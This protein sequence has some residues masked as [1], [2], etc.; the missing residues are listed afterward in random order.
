MTDPPVSK[1]RPL[2]GASINQRQ[3]LVPLSAT[4]Q[5]LAALLDASSK[6]E[7]TKR[8]KMQQIPSSGQVKVP[9]TAMP[10]ISSHKSGSQ[11]SHMAALLATT[12]SSG[13]NDH[14]YRVLDLELKTID[15]LPGR[16]KSI[17]R[18]RPSHKGQVKPQSSLTTS[19]K[20]NQ[21]HST[22]KGVA[23]PATQKYAASVKPTRE[24]TK[25][26]TT[27][28]T[29]SCTA[30]PRASPSSILPRKDNTAIP[31]NHTN[32]SS[33]QF[34]A[35]FLSFKSGGPRKRAGTWAMR[36]NQLNSAPVKNKTADELPKVQAD[37]DS[38]VLP[39]PDSKNT[40]KPATWNSSKG[41][42]P[43][44]PPTCQTI[45]T[46]TSRSSSDG[47]VSKAPATK[48]RPNLVRQN[49]RN[50]HGAC[51]HRRASTRHFSKHAKALDHN[52][53]TLIE[54]PMGMDGQT[55]T[56]PV[57]D[58]C[59]G[60]VPC[61]SSRSGGLPLCQG[62]RQP[63]CLRTV[64]KSGSIHKGR[65]FYA[66]AVARPEQCN[67]F[68]WADEAG[69]TANK[70]DSTT[71]FV[72][73]QVQA[74]L[75][76]LQSLTL[77]ELRKWAVSRQLDTR[78]RRGQVWARIALYVRDEISRG[79]ETKEEAD[80]DQEEE[81]VLEGQGQPQMT[82]PLCGDN[83]NF[84]EESDDELEIFVPGKKDISRN[85][86][87]DIN[88]AKDENSG[89][90][91]ETERENEEEL[92]IL[93]RKEKMETKCGPKICCPLRQRL[94]SLFG[95][96]DFRPGQEWTIRRCLEGQRTLLVAPT[97]MG[98]SLCYALPAAMQ[99]DGVVLVISPLLS[100]IQDQ[101]RELPPSLPAASL[102]GATPS[103]TL[104]QDL[105]RGRLRILYVSPERLV[106]PSFRRLL[107]KTT[108]NPSTQAYER[109]MPNVSL[110]CVDEAHCL[111]QVSTY[112]LL[113]DMAFVLNSQ[114][115]P[116]LILLNSL[117]GAIISD[118]AT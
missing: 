50:A 65:K 61:A 15:Q 116:R 63:C 75:G 112:F 114:V 34:A 52:E 36:P 49:L 104:L 108:W 26:T 32:P 43:P 9:T 4:S 51:R 14:N 58:F 33:T 92:K 81:L 98:K 16:K 64:R 95:H 30:R 102:S 80:A 7:S 107:S 44:S 53:V 90:D 41:M 117:S 94:Q 18:R 66:C 87:E 96:A 48:Y 11:P 5:K 46:S 77:P 60:I 6:Q 83:D 24:L 101:L 38:T 78:G 28:N 105:R 31:S 68:A 69:G 109:I 19:N 99:P 97:G 106:S 89:A 115:S 25:Q 76:H 85:D 3:R 27:S 91:E 55:G 59:D 2:L 111:S 62:H 54:R 82:L 88:F 57:D 74:Y 56:D 73:R 110:F 22:A 67:H 12:P 29:S 13:S 1:K 113:D 42:H 118:H 71:G 45:A 35:T 86:L 93:P 79:M 17:E 72:Q 103:P 21:A 47:S 23:V 84:A 40:D 8:R 39:P 20:L 10:S 100:L 70:E 37:T